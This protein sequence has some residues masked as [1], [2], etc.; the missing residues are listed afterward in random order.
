MREQ[1][2]V[3][4]VMGGT[5]PEREISLVSGKAIAEG[6]R[7]AGETVFEVVA[8]DHQ[9]RQ[10]DRLPIDVVFVAL[11]GTWG[12]DGGIQQLLEGRG[13]PYTGSGPAASRLGMDKLA[14]KA[15]F[16]ARGVP[17]P[18]AVALSAT[19]PLTDIT[20]WAQALGF[21]L[22]VKPRAQGSSIGV[23]IVREP[24]ALG[25]AVAEALHYGPQGLMEAFVPGREL[26]VGIL[27][28]EPLPIIE[29]RS[30]R[31]FFDFEAKY[32]QGEAE[33]L[34]DVPL[35]PEL[36]RQVQQAALAAY[37][38]LGCGGFARVDLRLSPEPRPYIM[39]VNTIPGFTPVSLFPEAARRR[40]LEFPELCYQL[41]S[42]A[43]R[44]HQRTCRAEVGSEQGG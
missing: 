26:T 34:F 28:E 12:E 42:I 27:D 18:R 6:L 15:A 39:E 25:S 30:Q 23:T 20:R 5:S 14:A 7:R 4:V 1:H 38:A 44:D 19:E 16:R 40:G 24:Q 2:Q 31:E 33:H 43:L 17:T 41:V 11:H 32:H 35:S 29:L 9:L 10:L 37:R 13:L 22:V 8:D 3:A 36:Y 21:P